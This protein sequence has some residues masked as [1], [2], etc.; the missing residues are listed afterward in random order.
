MNVTKC[1]DVRKIE[2]KLLS[3]ITGRPLGNAGQHRL[4]TTKWTTTTI[5]K[6]QV[7]NNF[8]NAVKY[9]YLCQPNS[10]IFAIVCSTTP[11]TGLLP[12]G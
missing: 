7:S 9:M 10:N 3:S 2:L 6:K 8:M 12:T 5:L 11:N 1:D 4:H